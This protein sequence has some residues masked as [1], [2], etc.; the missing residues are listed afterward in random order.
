MTL[1]KKCHNNSNIPIMHG[2]CDLNWRYTFNRF[3]IKNKGL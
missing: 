3:D 2:Y 1:S